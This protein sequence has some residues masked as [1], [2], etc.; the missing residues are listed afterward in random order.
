M[1]S[2]CSPGCASRFRTG[3]RRRATRFSRS[4]APS[5]RRT[6]RCS[7]GSWGAGCGRATRR[8]SSTRGPARFPGWP[9]APSKR[10]RS[11]ITTSSSA[12]TPRRGG[13]TSE[14]R[15]AVAN[16]KLDHGLNPDPEPKTPTEWLGRL[17]SPR[18]I[19][20]FQ[21][22]CLT[23]LGRHDE[24]R[25]KLDQFRQVLPASASHRGRP[26]TAR[27]PRMASDSPSISPGFA[28][29]CSRAGSRHG[30]F[31]TCTSPRSCSAWTRARMHATFFRTVVESRSG[32]SD[33]ARLSAAVVLSQILLLEHKHDLYA[34]LATETLA[35]L[36]LKL[37]RS[38]PATQPSANPLD[39]TRHVPDLVGGL[40]L[41]PLASK[42][43]PLRALGR[44]RS[45]R[46]PSGGKHCEAKPTTI[47]T[48]WPPTS[49]WRRPTGSSARS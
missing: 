34:E 42:T 41:L 36:L 4:G 1:P 23:K 44:T 49:S 5:A 11:A 15:R 33:T 31:K 25:A 26:R 28:M 20:V 38:L 45:S 46:R 9:S 40:A 14:P 2:R 43:F 10:H 35:P 7:P 22:H 17:F 30:S 8:R 13:G 19:A 47:S 37:R 39:L 48:A 6:D 24:A 21:F 32:E 3:R 12:S 27:R 18:G 29:R 16:P